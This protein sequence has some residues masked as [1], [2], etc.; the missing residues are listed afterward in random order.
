ME[1]TVQYPVWDTMNEMPSLPTPVDG[2][3]ITVLAA[4]M[5][6]SIFDFCLWVIHDNVRLTLF[7]G[8]EP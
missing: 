7:S 6:I 8:I 4:C 5:S 1:A 3:L 2:D